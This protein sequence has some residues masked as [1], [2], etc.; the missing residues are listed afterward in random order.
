IQWTQV[1]SRDAV[2]TY[3]KMAVTKIVADFPGFDWM[4]WARPQGI[5]QAPEW[6]IAQPS[7]FKGFAAMVPTTPIETW[8]AW[9]AAQYIT[10]DAPLLSQDFQNAA[11]DFFGRTLSGQQQ[12]RA[13]WKRG[14]QLVN[15][16]MGE[17]LGQLYVGKY[18]PEA[19]RA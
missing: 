18:Y 12:Q 1:E 3:N 17:A 11:F 4:A 9:L 7:F 2:K 8:K 6:V 10:L 19:A 16:T 13:R 14:V 15:G 5:D